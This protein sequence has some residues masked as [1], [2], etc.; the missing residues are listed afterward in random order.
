ME[1]HERMFILL[2]IAP[3]SLPEVGLS[4]GTNSSNPIDIIHAVLYNLYRKRRC[5]VFLVWVKDPKIL[6]PDTNVDH[7]PGWVSGYLI[8]FNF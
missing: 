6:Y 5:Y 4:Y 7:H 3:D 2:N 1:S 8:H